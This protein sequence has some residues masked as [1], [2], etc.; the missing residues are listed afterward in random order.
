MLKSCTFEEA[1]VRALADSIAEWSNGL[2]TDEDCHCYPDVSIR[3]L[4]KMYLICRLLD[5]IDTDSIQVN[6]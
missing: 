1:V 6:S 2:A 3:L 4:K 5:A